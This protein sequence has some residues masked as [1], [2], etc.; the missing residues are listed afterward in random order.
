LNPSLAR[1]PT[2][3]KPGMGVAMIVHFLTLKI[4]IIRKEIREF[5][6]D[7]TKIRV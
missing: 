6:A 5:T 4:S 2:L 3:N 7:Y 1:L